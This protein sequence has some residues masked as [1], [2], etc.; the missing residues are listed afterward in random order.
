MEITPAGDAA[1]FAKEMADIKRR[2]AALE[3]SR[4]SR[5]TTVTDGAILI[6][7]DDGNTIGSIG[8]DPT[9]PERTRFSV[10]NATTGE[11]IASLGQIQLTNINPVGT[12][13]DEGMIVQ[14]EYGVDIML[15]TRTRG[16]LAPAVQFPWL[17]PSAYTAVTSATWV[18][19]WETQV[20]WSPSTAV[21]SFVD[22]G[23]DAATTGDV[24]L[25]IPGVAD[26]ATVGCAAGAFTSPDFKW[27]TAGLGLAVGASFTVRVQARRTSGVGN[28]NVY[29]PNPMRSW[30]TKSYGADTD[31]IYP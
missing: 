14:D 7:D 18:D 23:C 21:Q 26:T 29:R 13:L 19:V 30:D 10:F 11:N 20:S 3:T 27:D 25:S 9:A 16:M 31:G 4:K 1:Q 17:T 22:V 2:L 5:T 28:V 8:R 15:I 6:V 12:E 24:R